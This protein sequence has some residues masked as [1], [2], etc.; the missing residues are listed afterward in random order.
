MTLSNATVTIRSTSTTAD[1]GLGN[2]TTA[3]VET[4]LAWA[5]IAPRSSDERSD[6]R[7]PAVIS[8]ATLYGPFD[9]AIDADDRILVA[10]HSP[11][12]DGEWQIEG[13]PGSWSLGGWRP[14]LEVA[15]K[16]T[17]AA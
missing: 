11:A 10:D 8:A 5:L 13:R 9:A 3:T 4:V 12:M 15:L 7:S 2:T 14:G 1:D 17:G 16:R 6:S